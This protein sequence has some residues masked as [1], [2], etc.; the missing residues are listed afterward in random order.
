MPLVSIFFNR[1]KQDK[2]GLSSVSIRV[3]SS[4]P[5]DKVVFYPTKIKATKEA[6]D[7]VMGDRPRRKMKD[8]R[9]SLDKLKL[10]AEEIIL[11][12]GPSFT[13]EQFNKQFGRKTGEATDLFVLLKEREE[14]FFNNGKISTSVTYKNCLSSVRK[15]YTKP[16]LDLRLVDQTFIKSYIDWLREE[17]KGS[18]GKLIKKGCSASTIGIYIRNIR[19]VFNAAI[20][21]DLIPNTIYP[22]KKFKIPTGKAVKKALKLDEISLIYK[23]PPESENEGI[24]KDYWMFSYLSGGMNLKDIACLKWKN[25]GEE[26]IKYER[27]KTKSENED[28]PVIITFHRSQDINEILVRR[29]NLKAKPDDYVFPILTK[30][31]NAE[32]IYK[33]IHLLNAFVNKYIKRIGRKLKIPLKVVFYAGRHSSSTILKN[34]GVPIAAI[35]EILGHKNIRTTQTYLSS[36]EDESKKELSNILS[37]FN[38]LKAV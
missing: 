12:L 23:Y 17:I 28:K 1:Y 6:F 29:A 27:E 35:S 14:L 18:D 7:S 25:V 34:S 5:T 36:F 30:Q 8:I 19:T 13:W 22:F 10:K 21:E 16:T 24:A 32:Q 38:K 9:L 2:N 26:Y 33:Q 31:M 37:D 20:N 3:F 4:L 15:F 11:K